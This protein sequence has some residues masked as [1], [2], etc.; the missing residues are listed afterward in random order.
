MR[1]TVAV[2]PG[3]GI[4]PEV[5]AQATRVLHLITDACGHHV[6]TTHYPIGGAALRRH[7]VALPASTAAGCAASDAVLLGAVGDPSFDHLSPEHRPEAA[8][9]SL[10]GTLGGFANL[11]PARTDPALIDATPYRRERVAGADLLLV[12]ELLGGLYYGSPRGGNADEAYNTLRYTRDE[13]ARVARVAF[14]QA[15]Q[16][17]RLVTSIDK[18]NVL[19]TSRLWRSTVND[20]AVNCHTARLPREA[21][22]VER[23]MHHV[24]DSGVRPADLAM[25]GQRAST[26]SEVGDAV[27]HA[28]AE[29]ID[30]QHAY[31]AV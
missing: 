31:H 12:R 24:L 14:E 11:R 16:R 6:E 30:H 18:A 27:C 17:R 22:L 5:I 2:L 10:R 19:E 9:L 23:A 20:V 3:D 28:L 26:T 29:V 25:P 7:G 13:L 1:L 4:G 8:L 21:A 15:R